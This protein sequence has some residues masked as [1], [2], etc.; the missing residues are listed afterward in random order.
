MKN[1]IINLFGDNKIVQNKGV[2]Y[3]TL[4]EKFMANFKSEFSE[5]EYIEN[6]FELA[7]TAWNFGNISV[8]AEEEEFK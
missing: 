5:M 6:I 2:K 8:I 7:I 4:L 1:K 3:S